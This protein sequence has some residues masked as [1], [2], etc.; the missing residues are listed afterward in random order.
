MKPG[1]RTCYV[2][3][4]KSRQLLRAKYVGVYTNYAY[5]SRVS[6]GLNPVKAS[7]PLKSWG[8]SQPISF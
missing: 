1:H 8:P 7:R 2:L 5:L 6:T 4:N 3:C